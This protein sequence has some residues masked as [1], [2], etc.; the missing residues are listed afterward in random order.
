MAYQQNSYNNQK[1]KGMIK[2]TNIKLTNIKL[3]SPL[4]MENVG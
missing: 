2:L 3:T 4:K 1:S